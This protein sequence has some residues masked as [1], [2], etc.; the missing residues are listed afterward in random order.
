[1]VF[2]PGDKTP[3]YLSATRTKQLVECHMPV[4]QKSSVEIFRNI[5]HKFPKYGGETV[6]VC[7]F[8]I[9]SCPLVGP[10]NCGV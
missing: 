3:V 9:V 1:M 8:S 6:L 2:E 10:I 7:Y 5:F 4:I